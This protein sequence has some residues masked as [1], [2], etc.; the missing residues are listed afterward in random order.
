[1][2]AFDVVEKGMRTLINACVKDALELSQ[3]QVRKGHIE[4]LYLYYK[5]S[6]LTD[7]GRLQLVPDSSSAPEGYELVTGEGLR[8][9]VPYQSYFSWIHD[10]VR[11][12]PLL[13][14]GSGELTEPVLQ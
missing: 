13:P 7:W 12:V 4:P 9:N 1:M 14:F 11:R 10:R 8:S 6:T 2:N 5:K 3:Q